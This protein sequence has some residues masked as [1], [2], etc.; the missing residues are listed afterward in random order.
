MGFAEPKPG[1]KATRKTTISGETA[2]DRRARRREEDHKKV[3]F[4]TERPRSERQ[5]PVM[6]RGRSYGM[7]TPMRG[8]QRARRRFDITI[9]AIPG[10]EFRAPSV[11]VYNFSW[12]II[13]G[14]MVV[15]MIFC[16]YMLGFSPY[17]KVATIEIEGIKRLNPADI[18]L[19]LGFKDDSILAIDP[20]AVVT[21]LQK[22]FPDLEQAR[23]EL[24]LPATV[25]IKAV[26]RTPVLRWVNDSG[27]HWVDRAGMIFPA[28]GDGSSLPLV[29]ADILP[30]VTEEM[31]AVLAGLRAAAPDENGKVPPMMLNPDLVKALI[32]LA[33]NVPQGQVL[34]Y[35]EA[36]GFGWTDGHGWAV[37]FGSEIQNIEQKLVV[38]Q[39]LAN[40]LVNNGIQPAMVSVE[41][42]HAPYYRME[43]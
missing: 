30:G 37:Y 25:R 28:R 29:Q 15:L 7:A 11:P 14:M 2:R 35:Q 8:S 1:R 9:S 42:L 31:L 24:V 5:P 3:N 20:K 6:A 43:R 23:V 34:L 36:H 41:Y 13:S 26:E 40:Y 22:A 38:Y 27:E 18:N 16:L 32:T 33:T 17:F 10:A 12:R 39:A 4:A 21:N 19:V